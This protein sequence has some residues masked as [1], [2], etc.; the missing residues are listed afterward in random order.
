MELQSLEPVGG[1]RG[2][3]FLPRLAIEQEKGFVRSML[4]V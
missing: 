2:S 1:T 3:L 4:T